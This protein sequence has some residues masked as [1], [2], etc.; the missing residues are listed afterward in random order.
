MIQTNML[1]LFEACLGWGKK[2]NKTHIN[3][4]QLKTNKIGFQIAKLAAFFPES[5]VQQNVYDEKKKSTGKGVFFCST[6]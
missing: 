5:Y 1:L 4:K 2:V 3:Q 6:L